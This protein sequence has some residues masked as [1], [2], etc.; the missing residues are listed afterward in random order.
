[1][2][3]EVGDY[4]HIADNYAAIADTKLFNVYYERPSLIQLIPEILT[5]KSVLD[6]GCGTGWYTERLAASGAEVISIDAC[7]SMIAFCKARLQDRAKFYIHDLNYQMH[8]IEN[9]SIDFIIAP[10]VLHYIKDWHLFFQDIA[11]VLKVGGQIAFSTHQ[12]HTI[13]AL[14]ELNSYFEKTIVTDHW[15]GIG[16]VQFYHHTL[17]ELF[18]AILSANLS[19]KK[20][21]EFKPLAELQKIKPDLYHKLCKKPWLIFCLIQK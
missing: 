3:I 2:H 7:E 21:R 20:I 5:K 15:E 4:K 16:Q 19:I 9:S 18:D 12:C 17:D 8:F 10:L 14:F 6:L 11:R 13:A 1:M